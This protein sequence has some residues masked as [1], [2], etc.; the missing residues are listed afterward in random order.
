MTQDT[1][2]QSPVSF[3]MVPV[4]KETLVP[5]GLEVMFPNL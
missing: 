1:M 3:A 4:P 5:W 2:W